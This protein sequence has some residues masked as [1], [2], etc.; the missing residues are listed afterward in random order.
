[1][2]SWRTMDKVLSAIP[3]TTLPIS[4]LGVL[5]LRKEAR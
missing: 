5:E 2:Q 4:A 1:V 3:G